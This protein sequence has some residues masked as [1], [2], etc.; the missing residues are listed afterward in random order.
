[1]RDNSN[2]KEGYYKVKFNGEW[3][4]ARWTANSW[5]LDD[6]INSFY[7]YCWWIVGEVPKAWGWCDDDFQD[8]L[9]SSWS[10]TKNVI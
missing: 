2:R 9:E 5:N 8:I 7:G 6:K 10:L 3:R 4:I 1:M